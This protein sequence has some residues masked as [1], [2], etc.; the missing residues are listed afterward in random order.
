MRTLRPLVEKVFVPHDATPEQIGEALDL[1]REE[2]DPSRSPDRLVMPFGWGQE[3]DDASRLTHWPRRDLPAG[4][5]W[6]ST[7]DA[8][9]VGDRQLVVRIELDPWV[10][11]HAPARLYDTAGVLLVELHREPARG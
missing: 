6:G 2:L 1:A 10:V 9:L 8:I 3:L 4:G 7:L 5:V 11:A